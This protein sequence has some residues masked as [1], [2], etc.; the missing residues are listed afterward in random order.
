MTRLLALAMAVLLC[1]EFD[2]MPPAAAQR[3][4]AEP[5]PQVRQWAR[6]AWL[7]T[8][9]VAL[10]VRW[11]RARGGTSEVRDGVCVVYLADTHEADLDAAERQVLACVATGQARATPASG[12]PP[13]GTVRLRWHRV[14]TPADAAA[15]YDSL[16][17]GL[18]RPKYGFFYL[19]A[20]LCHVVT[21]R[22]GVPA[23]G[24]ELKHCVDG[25]FH[26]PDPARWIPHER[27]TP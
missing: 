19:E 18:A 14:P 17:R 21:A 27:R 24:H 13:A 7:D 12:T 1:A 8:P 22:D 6:P 23:L 3:R 5:A 4:L 2:A 9:D 25:H 26:G 16:Y 20:G 10:D 15:R 11:V